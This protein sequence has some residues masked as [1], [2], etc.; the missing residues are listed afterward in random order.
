MD[1]YLH[2]AIFLKVSNYVLSQILTFISKL[3]KYIRVAT[4][5]I[6]SVSIILIFANT[7]SASEEAFRCIYTLLFSAG[8]ECI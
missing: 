5:Q 2:K 6:K 7:E 4:K 1:I 3:E 8:H